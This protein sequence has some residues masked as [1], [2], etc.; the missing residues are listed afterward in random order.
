MTDNTE[1]QGKDV[2][3]EARFEEAGE[4]AQ[5]SDSLSEEAEMEIAEQAAQSGF[6]S[7]AAFLAAEL[8]RAEQEKTELH[9]R[10]LRA[11]AEMENLRRRTQ[12][13]VADAREYSIAG[14][15]REMLQ[16]ADNLRRAIETIP[17]E[18]RNEGNAGL[19]ALIEGVEMTERAMMQ[20]LEKH[21]V[22]KISPLNEK[23][24]PNL[25]QAMFEIPNADVPNNT[26][27]NV[28][29][30]GFVIGNRCLRPAMVGVSKGGPKAPKPEAAEAQGG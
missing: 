7:P 21:G 1:H 15:A 20:G 18:S 11:H 14:F 22:K 13:D 6:S 2:N 26:V 12:K 25:H 23:F 19:N 9:E 4:R 30:E 24:D 5:A 27:L 29:Q 3:E 10:Y 8:E 16:V 28:V 17:E